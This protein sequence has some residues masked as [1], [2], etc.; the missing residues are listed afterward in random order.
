MFTE[1]RICKRI[2]VSLPINYDI[3]ETVKRISSN[4][5][6]KDISETGIRLILKRFYPPKAKFLLRITLGQ[7]S[8]IIEAIAETIWSFNMRSSDMY[9]NGSRFID[10][11]KQNQT[12]LKEYIFIKHITE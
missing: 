3:L 9:Y 1:R 11:N 8:K 7:E 5:V 4:T 6:C 2:N 12:L 10:M